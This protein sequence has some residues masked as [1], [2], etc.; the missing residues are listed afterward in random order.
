V[1]HGFKKDHSIATN[2]KRHRGQPSF[3]HHGLFTTSRQSILAHHG[4]ALADLR[5]FQK[6]S[7]YEKD[8][9]IEFL[10]T[11]QVLPAGIQH[12]IVDEKFES[13]KGHQR[14]C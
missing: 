1:V 8:S 14:D 5:A 12:L 4:E 2:S 3:F 10:K 11:L 9:L 13:G 6:I 7:E